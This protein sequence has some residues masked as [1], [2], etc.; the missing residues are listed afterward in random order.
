MPK[1]KKSE[2][3]GRLLAMTAAGPVYRIDAPAAVV[4]VS[5]G[6]ALL[7]ELAL[8]TVHPRAK[9]SSTRARRVAGDEAR[10][11]WLFVSGCAA[12]SLAALSPAARLHFLGEVLAYVR[13]QGNA[14]GIEPVLCT[15]L[16]AAWPSMPP[17]AVSRILPIATRYLR[18]SDFARKIEIPVFDWRGHSIVRLSCQG[19]NNRAQMDVLIDALTELM[20]LNAPTQIG[21]SAA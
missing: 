20:Q 3:K 12:G 16:N 15:A 9:V 1:D 5:V 2:I 8:R 19:Y 18:M 11:H 13:R 4:P 6:L 14:C 17:S 7:Q 21:F 10:R